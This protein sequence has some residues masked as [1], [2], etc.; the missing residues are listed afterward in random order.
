MNTTIEHFENSHPEEWLL[1]CAN[2]RHV[3]SGIDLEFRNGTC[4]IDGVVTVDSWQS[5]REIVE[6][7]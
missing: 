4:T 3:E 5:A 2:L 6:A 7:A 1:L